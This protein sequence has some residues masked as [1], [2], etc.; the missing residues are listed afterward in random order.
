MVEQVVHLV[1]AALAPHLAHTTCR[2]TLTTSVAWVWPDTFLPGHLEPLVW[3][4]EVQEVRGGRWGLVW[5]AATDTYTSYTTIDNT[6]DTFT[7]REERRRGMTRSRSPLVAGFMQWKVELPPGRRV[8]G[9]DLSYREAGLEE[10][11]V[12]EWRDERLQEATE[13]LVA[14]ALARAEE[15]CGEEVVLGWEVQ[16]AAEGEP[17]QGEEEGGVQ[18]LHVGWRWYSRAISWCQECWWNMRL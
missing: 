6:T 9:L 18:S 4:P 7:R 2:P 13:L 15:G 10:R 3:R 12:R 16:G 1:S 17:C 8:C 5:E 11:R 14:A